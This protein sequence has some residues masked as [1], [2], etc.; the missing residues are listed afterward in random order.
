M[1]VLFIRST[2]RRG[3]ARVIAMPLLARPPLFAL[4]S[5]N[6][7]AAVLLEGV[8]SVNHLVHS[9]PQM[10]SLVLQGAS[11]TVVPIR[12]LV[13]NLLPQF[14]ERS[15]N[16]GVEHSV[17]FGSDH[18][19]NHGGI[20]G[21][22]NGTRSNRHS[23][24]SD[25]HRRSGGQS[26]RVGHR[27]RCRHA[28]R[29]T[30]RPACQRCS[31]EQIRTPLG[32][33]GRGHR[34][35]RRDRYRID[36]R[37][38]RRRQSW[39]PLALQGVGRSLPSQPMLGRE[40]HKSLE[41][42]SRVGIPEFELFLKH[43]V[44]VEK[45]DVIPAHPWALQREAIGIWTTLALAFL[46]RCVLRIMWDPVVINDFERTMEPVNRH[47]HVAICLLR[48]WGTPPRKIGGVVHHRMPHVD[49]KI[50]TI[51]STFPA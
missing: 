48:R 18:F 43:C 20:D 41:S 23:H 15:G 31:I 36:S 34:L 29:T 6:L 45:D 7:L 17:E 32:L 37:Q 50:H 25:W 5:V 4:R 35:G 14:D 1:S 26:D 24:R 51:V 42:H 22:R 13:P 47:G 8:D 9:P 38:R 46:F 49:P 19:G 11:V 12:E 3:I 33:R 21:A 44:R 40:P 27:G 10:V 28:A 39:V 16:L 30:P 2:S